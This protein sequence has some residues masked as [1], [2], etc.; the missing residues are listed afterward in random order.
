[1]KLSTSLSNL[2]LFQYLRN[3]PHYCTRSI[4]RAEWSRYVSRAH[5]DIIFIAT[6]TPTA[7]S[8]TRQRKL[9]LNKNPLSSRVSA[10]TPSTTTTTTAS[11]LHELSPVV[12]NETPSVLTVSGEVNTGSSINTHVMCR[13]IGC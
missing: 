12:T 11:S 8:D 5:S 3:P 7:I 13:I 4:V 6:G 1:M 9:C 10:C 2:C